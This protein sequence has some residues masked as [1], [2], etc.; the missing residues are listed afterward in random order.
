VLIYQPLLE[1]EA[2]KAEVAEQLAAIL[3]A[4]PGDPAAMRAVL[5]P[6]LVRAID[7]V[8]GDY[9]PGAPAVEPEVDDGDDE[10]AAPDADGGEVSFAGWPEG[11]ADEG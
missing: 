11:V 9:V 2:S 4:R 7:Y 1:K 5:P 8:T 3:R 6:Y 10:D